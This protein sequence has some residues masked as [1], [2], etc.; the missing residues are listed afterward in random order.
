MHCMIKPGWLLH[1]LC[2]PPFE[3]LM[4]PENRDPNPTRP[5]RC[6]LGRNI[7]S[8]RVTPRLSCDYVFPVP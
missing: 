5:A 4:S 8:N 6:V 1:L 3:T 2:R 7:A